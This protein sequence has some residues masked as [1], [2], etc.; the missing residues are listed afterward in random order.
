MTGAYSSPEVTGYTGFLVPRLDSRPPKIT[1]ITD[2]PN[3]QGKLVNI[4]W[5]RSGYD[6]TYAIE[7]FYSVWRLDGTTAKFSGENGSLNIQEVLD[8]I[9]KYPDQSWYWITGGAAWTFVGETPALTYEQYAYDAST[10]MDFFPPDVYNYSTFKVVFHTVTDYFESEPAQG[11]SID[12]LSPSE[13]LLAGAFMVSYNQLD[14][15]ES[16]A[17]DLQ[18]YAVYKGDS[19]ENMPEVPYATTTVNQFN[20]FNPGGELVYYA[21]TAYDFNGNE[22]GLSNIV[23]VDSRIRLDLSVFLEGPFDG[24]MMQTLLNDQGMLP[25]QQPFSQSPWNYFGDESVYEI[26]GVPVVDWLLLEL[27]DAPTAAQAT[28]A[29]SIARQAVFLLADGKVV[30]TNGTG[31]PEFSVT[32][33]QQLFIAVWHRNHLA[34]LSAAQ[35]SAVNGILT[36]DLS[37]SESQVLGG[38]SGYSELLP[39]TWG[40]AAGDGNADGLV[41]TGDKIE[42]WST[43]AGMTGY[44]PGDLNLD[45]QVNNPDKNEVWIL[46]LGLESQVPE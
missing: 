1:A 37:S 32:I 28:P 18:Y 11:Y 45:G 20:D 27:R 22:S 44:L 43:S 36:L 35:P 16:Q 29:T 7:H 8:N 4:T 41:N 25:L 2:V 17:E 46:N 23:G 14:W 21:V 30:G 34:V 39:G 40:M 10:I 26:P 15:D 24:A 19:P 3:D 31:L 42:S 12:N 6:D 33:T 13:P 9:E 5:D 38:A